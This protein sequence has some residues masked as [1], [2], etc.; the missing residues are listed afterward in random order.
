[1]KSP[2]LPPEQR[3]AILRSY[4]QRFGLRVFI[5]TGTNTGDTPAALAADFD[6]LWTIEVGEAA[7]RAA[8]RRFTGTNVTCLHGDS[9]QMLARVLATV[10]ATPALL[11]LDGHFSGGDRGT[12]DTPVIEELTAVFATGVPHVV[13]IDDA[14]LFE[15]MSHFGEHDWPPI[16][17]VRRLADDHGYHF[18]VADDIIR[19]TP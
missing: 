10:G 11:W 2:S 12:K 16:D 4:G 3:R 15:G 5:E 7:Y 14:R 19:L 6:T 18:E 8:Y 13:L 1:M 9:G 17:D